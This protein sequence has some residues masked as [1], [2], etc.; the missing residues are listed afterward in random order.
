MSRTYPARIHS[1]GSMFEEPVVQRLANLGQH[2]EP[3]LKNFTGLL[4][5]IALIEQFH[6]KRFRSLLV[7]QVDD[8]IIDTLYLVPWYYCPLP[9]I[10]HL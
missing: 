3:I 10:F 4:A 2:S 1:G 6:Q 5:S 8:Y 9:T 7:E